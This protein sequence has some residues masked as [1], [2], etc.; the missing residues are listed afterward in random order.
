MKNQKGYYNIDFGAIML[1]AAIIGGVIFV[2][3]W[4]LLKFLWPFI[5]GALHVWT[6]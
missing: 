2:A 6:A 4:E 3:I 1:V 5:K